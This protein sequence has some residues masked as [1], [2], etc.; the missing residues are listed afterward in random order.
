MFDIHQFSIRDMTLCGQG[1]RSLGD[2]ATT[3]ETVAREVVEFLYDNLRF[4]PEQERAV[5]LARLFKTHDYGDLPPQ[6]QEFAR[7]VAATPE[8][9]ADTKCL[10]LLAT[11]G[12][13]EEWRD[14]TKSAGHQ[15]IPLTSASLVNRFPM[16]SNLILQLGLEPDMVV[17]PDPSCLR[18]ME[19]TSYNVFHVPKALG[20]P[21][22][23]EQDR[24]VVPY[25][26]GSALGFGGIMPSGD[27]FAGILFL[28]TA[29]SSEVADSFQPLALSIK[30]PLLSHDQQRVFA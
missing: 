8:L 29:V 2:G 15:A 1:L 11:I 18:M 24:F 28:R 25:G 10:T 22:I 23:P 7:Q 19:E 20:S 16:I 9:A 26:V 13:R 21:Y 6:Q 12:E 30:W 27:L 17:R 4:G 3:M 5:V 14:R